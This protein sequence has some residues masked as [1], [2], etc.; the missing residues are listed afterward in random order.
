MATPEYYTGDTWPPLGMVA[1]NAAG[2]PV[3]LSSA[4]SFRM[5]AKQ[6]LPV[7]VDIIDGPAVFM[8]P[9][10]GGTGD[11]TDGQMEY[12]WTAS[13]LTIVASYTPELEV[14]WDALS[15]PPKIETFKLDTFVVK[16]DND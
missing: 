3:D 9:D 10:R 4:A 14:T 8:D 12:F 11:G 6:L 16:A 13:D 2:A 5:I 7:G 15:T 1:T